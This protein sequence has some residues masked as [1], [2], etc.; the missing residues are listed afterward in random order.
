MAG[1]QNTSDKELRGKIRRVKELG[2]I[3]GQPLLLC[4]A[5]STAFAWAM[6]NEMKNGCS[7]G[8]HMVGVEGFV[9]GGTYDLKSCVKRVGAWRA[10]FGNI[11]IS[12]LEAFNRKVRQVRSQS[13]R[14]K[15][16]NSDTTQLS[17]TAKA[18]AASV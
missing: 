15:N 16:R 14:R 2:S 9:S 11:L 6:M 13:A 17:N 1:L 18:G 4:C 7:D 3:S 8:C 5:K 12:N 10:A